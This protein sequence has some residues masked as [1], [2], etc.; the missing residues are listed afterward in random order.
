MVQINLLPVTAKK[1]RQTKIELRIKVGP[2]IF[3]LVGVI[4]VVV[5]CWTILG[6]RLSGQRKQLTQQQE[7]LGTLKSSLKDLDQ[8]NQDKK[9]FQR[10]LEFLEAELKREVF[11][12]ESL[13]RLSNLVP[14]GIW[15]KKISLQ[16]TKEK[17]LKKY[18]SLRIDGSV[19]SLR[20]EEMIDLI[21]GFMN[22][23]KKDELFSE[24][25]SEIKLLSSKRSKSGKLEIMNFSLHCQFH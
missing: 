5:V 14:P 17:L 8:Q 16:T 25:F 10:R 7:Q 12:A 2:L 19:I 21:S 6:I 15:F 13:N 3:A 20:G 11:W 23:L 1:K 9:Q 24:Q 4:L 18:V 22:A